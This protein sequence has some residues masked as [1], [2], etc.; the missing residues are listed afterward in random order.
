MERFLERHRDRIFGV[1]S[2]PDRVLFRGTLTS[3]AHRDGMAK[4]LSSQRVLLKDFGA[5][6]QRMSE[7][8]IAHARAVA[9]QAGRP[10]E[11]LASSRIRKEDRARAILAENPVTE[12][13][14]AV[15]TCV[16]P[17]QSY[18][19]R[20]NRQARQLELV[21]QERKCLHVYFYLLDRE[22]GFMHIRLQS[23]FP[24]PIQVCVNG[25]EWLAGRLD[26]AGI[27]YQKQGNCF[28]GLEDFA[29][30]QQ[31]FDG[32]QQRRWFKTLDTLARRANPWLGPRARPR[33]YDYYWTI[34][35]DEYATDVVFKEAGALAEV[36]PR[37]VEHAIRHFA[38]QDVMRFLGRRSNSLFSGEV[39]SHVRTRP[40][41]I[42][43]KHW[44][45]E[46]SV[47][48]YDKQGCVL[49]I[50]TTINNPR[51]FRVRRAVTRRGKSCTAWVTMRKSVAD[52]PRRMD[53]ARA[54]NARYLEALAVVGEV[55]PVR[56][57]LDPVSQRKTRAGRPYRA[58][59]PVDREEARVFQILL[60]GEFL[61]QGLRNQDVRERLFPS[62]GSDPLVRRKNAGRITRLLRLLRAHGLI[63]K[64]G[65]ARYYR[66]TQKGQ[67]VMSTALNLREC[68]T[69]RL[70]A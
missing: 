62:R 16:E 32:F 26:R 69:S 4:F 8:I 27:G 30:A 48:M 23:W 36:Y 19:V 57:V 42:R 64:V 20:R 53:L 60:S 21:L 33:L 44:V 65:R 11:Y 68:D 51:R 61:L 3:I 63:A 52:M 14:I 1:L 45:E 2:G 15:L 24:F 56:G 29:R 10:L 59:R 28:V 37:L 58:L 47:K 12:G 7:G 46:N 70:V 34:R 50:E 18:T 54:A 67:R 41:G 13:L 9:E 38:S 35:E 49:R 55:A 31:I 17:C 40:E 22:F 6:A 39:R 43:I 25:R 66:V 5:Y